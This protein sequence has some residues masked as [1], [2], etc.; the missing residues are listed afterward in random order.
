MLVSLGLR[1]WGGVAKGGS[2]LKFR[3]A[4]GDSHSMSE[5]R[6]STTFGFGSRFKTSECVRFVSGLRF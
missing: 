3:K 6:L 2:H 4:E 1:F 5:T